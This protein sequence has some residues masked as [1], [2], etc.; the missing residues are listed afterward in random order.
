MVEKDGVKVVGVGCGTNIIL[1]TGKEV[2]LKAATGVRV[3]RYNIPTDK[4]VLLGLSQV[5]D[6]FH[7]MIPKVF[8]KIFRAISSDSSKLTALQ[9]FRLAVALSMMLEMHIPKGAIASVEDSKR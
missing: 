8:L 6:L 4:K 2:L 3:W 9:S 5:Y 7:R 1:S